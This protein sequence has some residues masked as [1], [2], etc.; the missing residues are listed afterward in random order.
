MLQPVGTRV[1]EQAELVGLPVI[2]HVG[3]PK[4]PEQEL[5]WLQRLVTF[6]MKP[7]PLDEIPARTVLAL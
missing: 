2:H 6:G 1:Q 7:G 5:T 4:T 3:I